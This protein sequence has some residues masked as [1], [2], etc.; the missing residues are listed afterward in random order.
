[1]K[2]SSNAAKTLT[3]YH[4]PYGVVTKKNLKD[5]KKYQVLVLSNVAMLD[6]EEIKAIR[7]FVADGGS[8]YASKELSLIHIWQTPWAAAILLRQSQCTMKKKPL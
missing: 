2:C 7:E 6:E 1:M 5:L 8:L 4:V 3:W